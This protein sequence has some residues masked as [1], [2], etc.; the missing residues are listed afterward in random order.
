MDDGALDAPKLGPCCCSQEHFTDRELD[1]L[2]LIASGHT[3]TSIASAL[4]ISVH[5]VARHVTSMLRRARVANRAALV[6]CA[7]RFGVLTME[8]GGP[9][10]SGRRCLTA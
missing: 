6:T 3:N 1:I 9:A 4:H 10:L 2:A 8:E 5:T 7:Y